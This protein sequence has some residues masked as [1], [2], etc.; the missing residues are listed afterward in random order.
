MLSVYN[1]PDLLAENV[2]ENWHF[3]TNLHC[4]ITVMHLVA[5]RV[6]DLKLWLIYEHCRNEAE[7]CQGVH[8]GQPIITLRIKLYEIGKVWKSSWHQ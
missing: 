1:K 6:D 2:H 5:D 4:F 7:S 3:K 8:L